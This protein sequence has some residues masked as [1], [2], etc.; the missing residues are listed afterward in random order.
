LYLCCILAFITQTAHG[1]LFWPASLNPCH[2]HDFVRI[3][4]VW[5]QI[6]CF[7]QS[8]CNNTSKTMFSGFLEFPR[9]FPEFPRRSPEVPGGCPEAGGNCLEVPGGPRRFPGG[10]VACVAMCRKNT[11]LCTIHA[12]SDAFGQF[13][14]KA[15]V[16]IHLPSISV[17][18]PIFMAVSSASNESPRRVILIANPH[19]AT[20][21]SPCLHQLL[22]ENNVQSFSAQMPPMSEADSRYRNCSGSGSYICSSLNHPDLG[23]RV[24]TAQLN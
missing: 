15:G 13:L 8:S 3:P 12:Q 16:L 2:L 19:A 11:D 18:P 14:T 6:T 1:T 20:P 9:R 7:N 17:P 10:V 5:S 24:K 22:L 21:C 23:L 4:L